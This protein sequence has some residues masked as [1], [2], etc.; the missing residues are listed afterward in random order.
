MSPIN[1]PHMSLRLDLWSRLLVAGPMG[2]GIAGHAVVRDKRVPAE[3]RQTVPA[4]VR[5]PASGR[6]FPSDSPRKTPCLSPQSPIFS[7]LAIGTGS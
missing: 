5:K 2:A 6:V 7:P 1:R 4:V 3:D